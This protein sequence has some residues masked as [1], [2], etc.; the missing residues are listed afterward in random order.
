MIIL[1]YIGHDL[2]SW[3]RDNSIRRVLL[4]VL[5]PGDAPG[6]VMDAYIPHRHYDLVP[7]KQG[8]HPIVNFQRIA[9]HAFW[10]VFDCGLLGVLR[11]STWYSRQRN[12]LWFGDD[13]LWHWVLFIRCVY[14]GFGNVVF[15]GCHVHLILLP[16]SGGGRR[17]QWEIML[18]MIMQ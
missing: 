9:N 3:G 12:H 1:E 7:L 13:T 6:R 11:L 5:G 14:S 16:H 4:L 8:L 17:P 10:G 15:R 2:V 18:Y